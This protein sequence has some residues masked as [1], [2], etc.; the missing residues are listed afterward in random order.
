MT[1]FIYVEQSN[2]M[3]QRVYVWLYLFKEIIYIYGRYPDENLSMSIFHAL[4][5]LDVNT[6]IYNLYPDFLFQIQ[7]KQELCLLTHIEEQ[8]DFISLKKN[9]LIIETTTTARHQQQDI[10]MEMEIQLIMSFLLSMFQLV[11]AQDVS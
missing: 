9:D 10:I 8:N 5:L 3:G 2:Q 1:F 11:N 4:L 6:H 7:K